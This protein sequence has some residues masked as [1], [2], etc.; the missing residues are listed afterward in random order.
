MQRLVPQGDKLFV[1]QRV[2]P[3]L[4]G[5]NR[6]LQ[7]DMP[8]CKLTWQCHLYGFCEAY[9]LLSARLQARRKRLFL[10]RLTAQHPLKFTH[11]NSHLNHHKELL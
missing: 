3:S 7:R 11:L 1:Q 9:Y 5:S 8:A 4:W 10:Q 6:L 2:R